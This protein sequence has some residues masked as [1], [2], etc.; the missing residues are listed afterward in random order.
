MHQKQGNAPPPPK[1]KNK[2]NNKK[3]LKKHLKKHPS[4][5]LG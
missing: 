2:H 4:L 1:N 5:F 3:N